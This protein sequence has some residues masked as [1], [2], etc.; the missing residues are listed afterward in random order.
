MQ[1]TQAGKTATSRS[2]MC[3]DVPGWTVRVE[4]DMMGK[5]Q[6]VQELVEFKK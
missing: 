1:T 2:W 5:M 3:K 6:V 4:S